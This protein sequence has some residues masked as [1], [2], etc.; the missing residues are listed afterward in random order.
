MGEEL[1]DLL[2][3]A[4]V[5]DGLHRI[6]YRNVIAVHGPVA[7]RRLEPWLN[8]ARLAAFAVITIT[9]AASHGA[10]PEARVAL[11][12]ARPLSQPVIQG[13]IDRALAALGSPSRAPKPRPARSPAGSPERALEELRILVRD[14]RDRGS[15]PQGVIKWRQPD[16]IAA[17]P[18]F[19][20]RL[21][22]LPAGLDRIDVRRV[23]SS[24]VLGQTEAVYAFLVVKAWGEGENGY[25]PSRALESLDLT[26]EPAKRLHIVAQTL[27]DR[28]ALAAYALLSDGGDCRIF[29]LGPAFGTKFLY[30]CQPDGQRPQA[31][32][33][34][35]NVS[36]WLHDHAG[37]ARGSTGW[38]L[39]RYQAYL[40]QMHSWAERLDCSPDDVEFCM[41]QAVLDPSNQWKGG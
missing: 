5:A 40:A 41:F 16:W 20:E 10:L 32:I 31:L 26:T 21:R 11:Q 1:D 18:Q 17:F 8:D 4:A 19:R 38:T 36:D 34:D 35:K 33:H 3:R 25:G 30:F 2:R 12:R 29:N 14:W 27:R 39:G 13:D 37:F 22:R 6:D 24:A 28:G 7:V 9:A 15:P 23:A